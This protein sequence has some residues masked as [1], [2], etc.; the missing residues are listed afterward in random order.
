MLHPERY[1][2]SLDRFSQAPKQT[3]LALFT[4]MPLSP[5]DL[6]SPAIPTASPFGLQDLKHAGLQAFLITE[7]SFP[8]VVSTLTGPLAPSQPK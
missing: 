2:S 8:V 7:M 1:F 5:L 4:F 6:C 3:Y